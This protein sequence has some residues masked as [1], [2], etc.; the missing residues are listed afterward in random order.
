MCFVWLSLVFTFLQEGIKVGGCW[1]VQTAPDVPTS[2]PPPDMVVGGCCL[3]SHIAVATKA[4]A[5]QMVYCCPVCEP[6]FCR[7]GFI[8]YPRVVFDPGFLANMLLVMP[9]LVGHLP[10]CLFFFCFV[11]H[12]FLC[13]AKYALAE[14]LVILLTVR[15]G[16]VHRLFFAVQGPLS[17]L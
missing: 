16:A 3:Q 2:P 17:L 8:S 4:G 12:M 6:F 10:V 9:A 11:F 5:E 7:E 14:G 1:R 13:S 15:V